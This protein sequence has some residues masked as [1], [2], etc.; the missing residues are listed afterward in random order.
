MQ[1]FEDSKI[2]FFDKVRFVRIYPKVVTG[3][4]RIKAK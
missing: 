2:A 4:L 3:V 1:L